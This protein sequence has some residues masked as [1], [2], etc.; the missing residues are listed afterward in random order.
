M[1][2]QRPGALVIVS[3][4]ALGVVA[5]ACDV[6][7]PAASAN[8]T[9]ISTGTLNT[10]LKILDTTAA[11]GCLL[12]LQNAQLTQLSAVGAGGSG[13]Y[14]TAFAGAV[15]K[16]QVGDLLAAQYAAS[17]GLTVS[18]RDLTTATSDLV[19]TLNGEINAEVQQA[20]SSGAA[21]SCQQPTG[22]SITGAT[23]LSGL[24]QPVR[25][26]QI[27]NEAVDEKLLAAGADLSNRAVFA[28]YAANPA[29]FTAVCVSR[30]A[31]DT[32]AH[33]NQL[34]AQLNGGA[35]FA[36]VAKANSIDTQTAANGG[37]LG[38]NFTEATVEQA[39][40]LKS[41]AVGKPIAPLQT[42]AGQWVIYEV[43]N[44]QV[45]PLS[46]AAP[47]VRRELLQTTGNVT[48]VRNG[49]VGFARHSN[50]SIDPRYGTWNGL[51]IVAPVAP[52][53]Q[54]LL[55]AA[56]GDPTD[57]TGS[58][59]NL[60]GLGSGGSTGTPGSSGSPTATATGGH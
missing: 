36:D 35:A 43:T 24:P 12:Q 44:Q 37:A 32:Q 54:Y 28:Y 20:S 7:S 26:V 47:V 21:S 14:T 48:R 45:E 6:T 8:G 46:A 5:S 16:N 34:I 60:N 25:T 11:G 38:C 30:I 51:N 9:P 2:R 31:T 13:T 27:R 3:I 17:K 22:A 39:L 58:S 23:L 42:N 59:L 41:I 18:S 19:A 10:Q 1:K 50:V 52:P 40:Q 56:S 55:A 15:L 29:L 57:S 53:E 4:L 49:I 33:A